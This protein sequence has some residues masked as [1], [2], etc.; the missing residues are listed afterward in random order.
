MLCLPD[1]VSQ[2]YLCKSSHHNRGINVRNPRK[3]R[4]RRPV[5]KKRRLLSTVDCCN[6][7]PVLFPLFLYPSKELG[8]D[9]KWGLLE[10]LTVHFCACCFKI[11]ANNIVSGCL[12]EIL[13]GY[14]RMLEIKEMLALTSNPNATFN[15]KLADLFPATRFWKWKP[16]LWSCLS[17]AV[18]SFHKERQVCHFGLRSPPMFN[19][20]L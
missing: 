20:A 12:Q 1:G 6:W 19:T 3:Y 18:Y 2:T 9:L 10:E 13:K 4:S 7:Y 15:S 5:V 11:V 14:Q 16:Y 17:W 8:K